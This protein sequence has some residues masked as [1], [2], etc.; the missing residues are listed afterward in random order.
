MVTANKVKVGAQVIF[1]N[2][3]SF[4]PS[5]TGTSYKVASPDVSIALSLSGVLAAAGRQ[6]AKGDLGATR[7]RMYEV[8]A[9]FDFTG[10]SSH[11]S[12]EVVDLYWA[13]SVSTTAGVGNV[14]G[15]SGSDAACPDG[16]VGG[17]TLAEFLKLCDYIGS[18]TIHDGGA[19]QNGFVGKFAPSSRY[20]QL[21]VVNNTGSAFEAS[22]AEAHV[23]FNE[24]LDEY[25]N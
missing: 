22:N 25:Q 5:D 16:A 7:A 24:I 19:V 20:G 11:T 10:E 13:P 9:C 12:G 1:Y 6:S 21:I 18:L 8:L 2:S 17:V 15:N 4:S 3:G 14:A 23:V